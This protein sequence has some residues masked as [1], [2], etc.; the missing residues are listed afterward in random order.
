[1]ILDKGDVEAGFSSELDVGA[2]EQV[3][4]WLLKAAFFGH[5][6]EEAVR[7]VID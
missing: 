7:E 4:G 1:M 6:E 2:G 5:S 3:E